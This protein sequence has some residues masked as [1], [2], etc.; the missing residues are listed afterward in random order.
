MD[1]LKDL[2]KEQ[3]KAVKHNQGPL[4]IVAGAGTGKTTVITHRLAY[5]VTQDIAKTDEI[6]ALTFTEKAAQ[7]MEERI[8]KLLPYGYL[9]LWISTFHAFCQRLLKDYGL[10]IGLAPDFKLLTETE[11]WVLVRKNLSKFNLSYYQ[12]LGRP[13]KF[14]KALVKHLSRLKDEAI[15]PEEYLEYGENLKLNG[16]HIDFIKPSGISLGEKKII[17]GQEVARLTEIAEGYQTYQKLLQD[18]GCLDFGDLINY[19]IKLLKE[20]PKI[21]AELR[22]RFK[23]ILVD[24]FQDTNWAQFELLRLLAAPNNNITVVGDDDQSV[25]KFRGAS[26]SNILGFKEL[27]PQSKEI[28]LTTNY[29]S[30]QNILDLAYNFIQL[31]N[32]DRLE[33]KLKNKK[34]SKKLIA[35][36]KGEGVINNLLAADADDEARLVVEKI[37]ELLASKQAD[38]LN[39]FAIL[40][41]ANSSAGYFINAL[42]EREIDYQFLASRGL[43]KKPII[44]D[45]IAYFKLLDDYHESVALYRVLSWDNFKIPPEEIIKLTHLAK[46]KGWSL[47]ETLDKY[48]GQINLAKRTQSII[49]KFKALVARHSEIAKNKSPQYLLIKVLADFSIQKHLNDKPTYENYQ[50]L[51]QLSQLFKEIVNFSSSQDDARLKDFMDYL[52]IILESGEEGSLPPMGDEGP[53]AVTIMTIHSAKGLEFAY[54]FIVNLVDKRFPTTERKELITIPEA[55]IKEKLPVGDGHLQEERRLFYVAV[56]RAKKGVYFTLARDYGGVTAKKPSR[57]LKEAALIAPD[58]QPVNVKKELLYQSNKPFLKKDLAKDWQPPLPK[59]L[60]F[61]QFRAFTTC[62][63]QYRYAFLLKIPVSGKAA[64]SFGQSLHQTLYQMYQLAKGRQK[65]LA[66]SLFAKAD[67]TAVG[68]SLNQLVVFKEIKQLYET[69]WQDDWFDSASEQREYKK[70]GLEQLKKYYE[71]NGSDVILPFA[72][73]EDFLLKLNTNFIKGRIDRLDIKADEVE[74]IDYKTGRVKDKLTF[75]DKLQLLIYELALKQDERFKNKNFVLTFYYLTSNL[76]LS[77]TASE[78]DLIKA[79]NYLTAL[80]EKMRVSDFAATP[81]KF[82][83]AS[84]DFKDICNF[85]E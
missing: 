54:V 3:L 10:E 33:A 39:D 48:H 64:L 84:C 20:R 21:L 77:F 78:K 30:K 7:E 73:E 28:F 12:P 74:I 70:Q 53:E 80:A 72:L 31:N 71:V 2:N 34:L 15:T 6:L 47:F 19:T 5:L 23:Y 17:L 58:A 11:Q 32:P 51:W 13:T 14:I 60:S 85:R 26:V 35:A 79:E 40:V 1:L 9:D 46:R 52:N 4:L 61:S 66:G 68:K 57:F 41:R 18:N 82:T 67:Q 75:D 22:Q 16:D 56:T 76:R 44:Q 45:V 55:L 81:S 29:R 27:Y 25:Y 63:Y 83:C 43:F 62:P 8:D 59:A 38:S 42:S 50:K 36:S 49:F 24:E 37:V 65:K 69:A